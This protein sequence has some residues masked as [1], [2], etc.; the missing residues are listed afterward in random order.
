MATV[1]LPSSAT[2]RI[3][4]S[5]SKAKWSMRPAT[6]PSG[7]LA[8]RTNGAGSAAQLAML[9]AMPITAASIVTR[10][11]ALPETERLAR[12]GSDV[13]PDIHLIERGAQALG[14]LM[15]IVVGPEVQEEHSRLF[16]EHVAVQGGDLDAAG[17]QGVNHRIDLLGL[18]H[19]IA[20]DGGG[21]EPRRLEVDGD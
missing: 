14:Q 3:C 19:E 10:S 2:N 9:S 6:A 5:A 16:A 12:G 8:S 18:Q 7:I 17:L 4:W 13:L 11:T 1:L 15:R 21:V 20:G